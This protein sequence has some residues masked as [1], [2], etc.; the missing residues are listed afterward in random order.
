M[1]DILEQLAFFSSL[2]QI[3]VGTHLNSKAYT[4][5]NSELGG[6]SRLVEGILR[7]EE[8]IILAVEQT[9]LYLGHVAWFCASWEDLE[10]ALV[11]MVTMGD[12]D[13]SRD[14]CGT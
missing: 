10:S 7:V 14:S 6:L 2:V 4:D 13:G 5:H 1:Y 11:I 3:N 12:L 9:H 8:L